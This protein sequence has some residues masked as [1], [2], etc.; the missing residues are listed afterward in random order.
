MFLEVLILYIQVIY[1]VCAFDSTYIHISIAFRLKY[2]TILMLYINILLSI[3][4]KRYYIKFADCLILGYMTC[5]FPA[6]YIYK[7][8]ATFYFIECLES[9]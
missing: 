9:V 1:I 5:Q 7:P 8:I 4:G 6:V 2:P 3:L